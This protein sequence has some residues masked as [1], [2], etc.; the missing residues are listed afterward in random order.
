MS[1][2]SS[3]KSSWYP[4]KYSS[5]LHKTCIVKKNSE[6]NTTFPT[7]K[8]AILARSR[9]VYTDKSSIA[10]HKS[11]D[12]TSDNG[13]TFAKSLY[14][15]RDNDSS[16]RLIDIKSSTIAPITWSDIGEVT[17]FVSCTM[18]TMYKSCKEVTSCCTARSCWCKN[19]CTGCLV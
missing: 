14:Y 19:S 9:I 16:T 2:N 13:S 12:T 17:I 8:L 18:Y 5:T 4:G 3:S 10:P 1:D 6:R 7:G 11:S 15:T